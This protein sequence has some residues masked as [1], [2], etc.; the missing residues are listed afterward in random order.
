MIQDTS[1]EAY[2]NIKPE[3]GSRQKVVL[4]VIRHLNSPTN[5]EISRYLGLPINTITPRVNEL[6]K[7]GLVCNAGKRN[8]SITGSMVYAWRINGL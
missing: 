5:V 1:M 4:D 6:R 8:C 7:K 3:L 2:Q